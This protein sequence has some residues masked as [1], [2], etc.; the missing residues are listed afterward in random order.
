M[1][2][3]KRL[4]VWFC[5][6]VARF[7][8][9]ILRPTIPFI[10]VPLYQL[11]RRHWRRYLEL[12]PDPWTRRRIVASSA[13]AIATYTTLFIFLMTFGSVRAS[14]QPGVVSGS[15]SILLTY[16]VPSGESDWLPLED[17]LV[18]Q[19]LAQQ[20][21]PTIVYRDGGSVAYVYPFSGA[22]GRAP[23]VPA[24][25]PT[26]QEQ[27][28]KLT[29]PIQKYAVQ[30]GDTLA[31]IARKFGIKIETLLW[32]NNLKAT[33]VLRPGDT[34]TVL[35][36]DGIIY[37]VKTGGTIAD[38][39][40]KHNMSA[41]KVALAN[42][43]TSAARLTKGQQVIVPDVRPPA[44]PKPPASLA[45]RTEQQPAAQPQ[46]EQA[47][48]EDP[49]QPESAEP[50]GPAPD[51]D[52]PTTEP[53]P[54]PPT[55]EVIKRPPLQPGEKMLWPTRRRAITQYYSARHQGLDIDGDYT[56]PVYAIDDGT[57]TFSGWNNSGYGNM[58]LIDH[59]NGIVSRYGHNSKV[60]VRAGQQVS[61]GDIIAMVGTTGRST[62]THLHF[63]VIVNGRRGNPF[64]YVR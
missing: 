26:P 38:V 13:P 3:A 35:A 36:T 21:I 62:G 20:H 32:A 50:A 56:D 8:I 11:F 51:S 28:Q 15:H 43:T 6:T 61:R 54:T 12:S 39:A 42:N 10:I 64:K 40:R 34:I 23:A 46:R 48:A 53:E 52:L 47:P 2:V 45:R 17:D 22:V 30:R 18:V 58:V 27:P 14:D 44:E 24:D 9:W 37:T 63:E 19:E 49:Q 25:E 41:Q 55:T 29:A 16:F 60:Y 33:S 31:K 7:F 5:Q 1:V 4:I 59:G 57:I